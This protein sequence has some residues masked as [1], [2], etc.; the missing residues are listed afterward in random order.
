MHVYIDI[1]HILY[2]AYIYRYIIYMYI[3]I[4]SNINVYI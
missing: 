1:Y 2:I 4:Y 3:Y